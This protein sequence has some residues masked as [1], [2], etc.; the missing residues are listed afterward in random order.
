MLKEYDKLAPGVT[1]ECRDEQWLVNHV[2]RTTDGYRVRAR[3]VSEYVR[4][5]TAT[6]F[7][8]LDKISVF[9]PADVTVKPDES[10]RFRHSR[11]WLESTLRRTPVPLYQPELEVATQMLAD[12]LDYQLSAVQHALSEDHIRP[13][14]LLADAVGLGKTLEI[15]MIL[16]ELI[17]RGRG[18]RILVVTPKH[19]MEQFQQE[20][21]TR[22][23]IPLVRL[24]SQGIQRVRQKLPASKNPFTYFPRVIV[25]MDTLKS[26]KYRAQLQ[27][28]RWDAVVID[29]IHNATNVGSQNNELARTLAPTTESLILASATPHNGREE[30]FKEILRFLDPLSVL[31]DGRIDAEAAQNLIIRRHRNSPE[32]ARVVGEKWAKRKEPRNILVEASAEENAVAREISQTWIHGPEA[33]NLEARLFPWTLVKAYLSSPAALA[34][35]IESRLHTLQKKEAANRREIDN[36]TYLRELNEKT[37]AEN[38]NKFSALVDYLMDIGVSR[39]SNRRVVIFSERVPTLHW[40]K[41]NLEKYLKLPADAVKVMHGGLP[42]TEQLAL[43]DEFKRTDTP[44]RVLITGDV[45]SEGVNL[46]AQC[47]HLVHYDIPWSLIRIQ[48]RN[49]R[50][51]RYG[52]LEEPEI[53]ALL[54]DPRDADSIG[55]LRVLT[56]LIEREYE[57][58]K[59]LGDAAP[60]LGKYSAEAEEDAIRDTL[61]RARDFDEVVPTVDEYQSTARHAVTVAKGDGSVPVAEA[62]AGFFALLMAGATS[63]DVAP[64]SLDDA[65][66]FPEPTTAP[67]HRGATSLYQTEC[68]YLS[69]ALGEAFHNQQHAPLSAGGVE[70]IEHPNDII[71]LTPPRDLCRRF[72]YLPQD[73]VDYRKVKK[74]LML[75][76]STVRGNEQL[77]AAREG[78]SEKSWPKAHFLG[79]LHP[80]TDW[81]ADRALASMARGEIPA[82]PGNVDTPTVLLMGT[83]TNSR[84]QVLTRSFLTGVEGLRGMRTSMGSSVATVEV[85]TDVYAWLRETVFDEKTFSHGTVTLSDNA[86]RLVAAAVTA[87]EQHLDIIQQAAIDAANDRTAHWV[88]RKVDWESRT[89]SGRTLQHALRLIKEEEELLRSMTPERSL[90]RPLIVVLPKKA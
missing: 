46:H 64:S 15:G 47:H 34:E 48:Q 89:S 88:E 27:K 32:V 28:V 12:P 79:P 54:L 10:P 85:L 23:A 21:W 13:R 31:P 18:E 52:Q 72:D 75:A 78:D 5:T 16:A 8:A 26:P 58:N 62:N 65:S 87:A 76:T 81:A 35:S 63:G 66:P 1:I 60:L 82:L 40:L 77:R 53:V 6:F 14:V 45:A 50:I 86:E 22:F 83:L 17:R 70:F 44:L 71:E 25:S 20:L 29:E 9:D 19:V 24:D 2:S 51:D 38:S 61:T 56:R 43:I 39:R 4:D 80:V 59:L 37:T 42:D 74:R 84:G 67:V 33:A 73:Y 41:K 7:T 49:G 11:L 57:A 55:E 3:G 69:D 36:L 90:I 30:S 68:G